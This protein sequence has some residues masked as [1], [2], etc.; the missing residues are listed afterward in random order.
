MATMPV[1][2][3]KEMSVKE[4]VGSDDKL[5]YFFFLHLFNQLD[6][7]RLYSSQDKMY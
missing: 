7:S 3:L 6:D 2:A 4:P 1:L 5:M